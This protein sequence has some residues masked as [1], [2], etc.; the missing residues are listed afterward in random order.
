M[1]PRRTLLGAAMGL[2][3]SLCLAG[4][5][6]LAHAHDEVTVYAAASLKNALDAIV[7]TWQA[8]GSRKVKISYAASSAL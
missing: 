5:P 3:I 4:A 8:G 6:R 7:A 2:L 1:K